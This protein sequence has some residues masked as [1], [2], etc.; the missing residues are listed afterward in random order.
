MHPVVIA[1]YLHSKSQQHNLLPAFPRTPVTMIDALPRMSELVFPRE[2]GQPDRHLF[3]GF[4]TAWTC[5]PSKRTPVT[6]A[7]SR[8]MEY[9]DWLHANDDRALANAKDGRY[10]TAA[11]RRE[12]AADGRGYLG[13]CLDLTGR[14]Y[15]ID[16]AL[17][18]SRRLADTHTHRSDSVGYLCKINFL[19]FKALVVQP[20]HCGVVYAVEEAVPGR[21]CRKISAHR[22]APLF[23]GRVFR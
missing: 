4:A 12:G 6:P 3:T 2:D 5:A 16:R 18:H 9:C 15:H 1:V 21:S 20:R 11:A 7:S 17:V 13:F 22:L 14:K 10:L 8:T 23:E 19:V